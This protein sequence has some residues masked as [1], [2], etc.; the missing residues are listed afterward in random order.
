MEQFLER[1]AQL[2]RGVEWRIEGI[3]ERDWDKGSGV[4]G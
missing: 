2:A 3:Q 1:G 4:A